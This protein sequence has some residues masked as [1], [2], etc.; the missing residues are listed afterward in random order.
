VQF[1]SDM[2]SLVGPNGVGKSTLLKVLLGD[3][4]E[5]LNATTFTIYTTTYILLYPL[6][7]YIYNFNLYT[8]TDITSP[9]TLLHIYYSTLYT[10][11][12]VNPRGRSLRNGR[13]IVLQ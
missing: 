10:A 12:R 9:F 6:H 4:G 5:S 1:G 3:S 11:S 7:S 2:E 8:T 13:A